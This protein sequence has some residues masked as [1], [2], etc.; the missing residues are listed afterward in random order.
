MDKWLESV[1]LSSIKNA[2]HEIISEAIN[3]TPSTVRKMDIPELEDVSIVLTQYGV[4]LT[5]EI[6]R[7]NARIQALMSKVQKRDVDKP[8]I[9]EMIMHEK[10]K[11]ARIEKLPFALKDL[12]AQV[13]EIIKRRIGWN[14]KT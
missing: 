13:R 8:A 11:L 5:A 10:Y 14:S 1:S 4:F 12:T 9:R 3:L 6:G 2:N 7:L